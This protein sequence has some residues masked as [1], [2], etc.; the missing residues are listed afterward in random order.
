MEIQEKSKMCYFRKRDKRKCNDTKKMKFSYEEI[1]SMYG[2]Y[3][4]FVTLEF[5]IGCE[6]YQKYG[7]SLMGT[8]KY[9][10]EQR[11]EME[12]VLKL[13]KIPRSKKK[14][15]FEPSIL[16]KQLTEEQKID[17]EKIGIPNEDIC[18]VSSINKPRQ[19]VFVQKGNKKL[20]KSLEIKIDW[21]IKDIYATTLG[22]YRTKLKNGIL[23]TDIEKNDYFASLLYF[24]PET[25]SKEEREFICDGDTKEIRAV[26][27][28]KFLN[29]KWEIEG[30]LTAIEYKE[31]T[32]VIK[33]RW[34]N[35]IDVL[36]KEIQRSGN[37]LKSLPIEMQMK[38]ITLSCMFKNEILLMWKKPIWWD[39]ER[40]LHI[41]LR[42]IAE[43]QPD[44]KFK[45]K[46][47]FQYEYKDI[48][49]LICHVIGSVTND[50]EEEFKANPSKNFNRQ[51]KRA[52][53][54]NGNYYK[55]EIEPSGRLLTFHAY[56]DDKEREKD[57]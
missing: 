2:Q 25:I 22:L 32:K 54:Y 13:E 27:Q 7:Q 16:H 14:V 55:V 38:L 4:T 29:I 19:N 47:N 17:L 43:L 31:Y 12:K 8:F 40:F 23:L 11:D 42:H 37:N 48:R 53:Y 28:E 10:L 24:K 44:G 20:P 1:Y 18:G 3:D 52:V 15:L 41:Y 50:I 26:I 49:Y 57:C 56:N 33:L 46:T 30:E 6:S 39:I 21:S 5:H 36:E 9:T 35:N 51:G 34:T 45:N